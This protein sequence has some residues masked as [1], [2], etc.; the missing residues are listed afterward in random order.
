M[1]N[2]VGRWQW[3]VVEAAVARFAWRLRIQMESWMHILLFFVAFVV[4]DCLMNFEAT[5]YQLWG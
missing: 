2:V 3:H 4:I 5:V 1:R